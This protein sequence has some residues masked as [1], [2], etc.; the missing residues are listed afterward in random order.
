MIARA[1]MFW[2]VLAQ[3]LS[4]QVVED[5]DWRASLSA[6][7]EPWEAA[8]RTFAKGAVRLAIADVIEPAAG[9]LYMVVLSPPHDEL[10][11]RQCKV[12]GASPGIGFGGMTLAGMQSGYDP[13]QGLMFSVAVSA[14]QAESG[15]FEDG[16]LTFTVNQATGAI[17]AALN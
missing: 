7:P 4:A 1:V 11:A 13:A 2:L 10:G 16:T 3:G 17:S 6:L 15:D 9:A 14:F 5:C 12:I 8:T